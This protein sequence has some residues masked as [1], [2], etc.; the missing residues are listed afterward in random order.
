MHLV[1]LVTVDLLGLLDP[2][3][4]LD[5]LEI[6]EE[7]SEHTKPEVHLNDSTNRHYITNYGVNQ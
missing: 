1:L 6:L 2:Q 5:L 4:L 7:R 3:D